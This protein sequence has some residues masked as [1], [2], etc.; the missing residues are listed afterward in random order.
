M[1]YQSK[2]GGAGSLGIDAHPHAGESCRS[3]AHHGVAAVT[4][5]AL[6]RRSTWSRRGVYH[7]PHGRIWTYRWPWRVPRCGG[8]A[9][10]AAGWLHELDRGPFRPC[11]PLLPGGPGSGPRTPRTAPARAV[12][13]V[14]GRLLG[15]DQ[16]GCGSAGHGAGGPVRCW[17][18]SSKGRAA[19]RPGPADGGVL[20]GINT[21][22]A[23]NSLHV[24]M[25]GVRKAL[26]RC[27]AA[28]WSSGGVTPTGSPTRSTSG[29]TSLSSSGAAAGPR[30]R[31]RRVV[32]RAV[33]DFEAAVAL[34][35]A[36]SS[37]TTPT[38]SGRS[39]GGRSCLRAVRVASSSAR[40]TSSGA[41]SRGRSCASQVLREEPC[42]SRWRVGYRR[43]PPARSAPHGSAAVRADRRGPRRELGVAPAPETVEL[44]DPIRRPSGLKRWPMA[45]ADGGG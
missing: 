21:D 28:W 6:G 24:A 22:A 9:L 43:V 38:S 19:G 27:G 26:A 32:R 17:R 8:G 7:E 20:A 2:S 31:S 39:G 18:T 16:P 12:G 29:P 1:W 45:D 35:A 44:A 10:K 3:A 25:C 33:R 40:C 23:R 14:P 11:T 15:V 13:P 42:Q 4:F 5:R 36:S 37:P 34:T 41:T 30:G